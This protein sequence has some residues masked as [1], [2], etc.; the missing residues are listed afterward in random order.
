MH[1][2]PIK[3]SR[4][5]AD[6]HRAADLRRNWERGM[7][8]QYGLQARVQKVWHGGCAAFGHI[9]MHQHLLAGA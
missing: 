9:H 3:K 8:V 5:A 7:R 6:A 4:C 1:G 2:L